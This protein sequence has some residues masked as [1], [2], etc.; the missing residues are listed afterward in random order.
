MLST[1]CNDARKVPDTK[2]DFGI[3]EEVGVSILQRTTLARACKPA[4]RLDA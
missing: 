1:V 2:V 3:S 4:A